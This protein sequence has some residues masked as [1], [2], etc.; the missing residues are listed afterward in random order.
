MVRRT[1]YPGPPTSA[2][3]MYSNYS[4]GNIT[5]DQRNEAVVEYL[6]KQNYRNQFTA[7]VVGFIAIMII[8]LLV[9]TY[10]NKKNLYGTGYINI[11]ITVL[12]IYMVTMLI[13]VYFHTRYINNIYAMEELD[14]GVVYYDFFAH[15]FAY[16]LVSLIYSGICL[17]YSIFVFVTGKIKL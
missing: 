17:A 1:T 7:L 2:A 8:F 3:S 11:A 10:P 13:S 9:L 6:K 12:V 4:S 14:G 15:S 5:I 16:T